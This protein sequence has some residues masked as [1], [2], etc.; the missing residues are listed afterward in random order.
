[1]WASVLW[2]Q[3]W[4]MDGHK[5]SS[6]CDTWPYCAQSQPVRAVICSDKTLPLGA[7]GAKMTS[8]V[9]E[10][11][12]G[13]SWKLKHVIAVM[14][15]G[16]WHAPQRLQPLAF[17]T[18]QHCW[19][20]I[21]TSFFVP[22]CVLILRWRT[23]ERGDF[24][25]GGHESWESLVHIFGVLLFSVWYIACWIYMHLHFLCLSFPSLAI[26]P[27]FLPSL[28]PPTLYFS[29]FP[30]HSCFPVL[31]RAHFHVSRYC[32]WR[33][34]ATAHRWFHS[35]SLPRTWSRESTKCLAMNTAPRPTSSHVSTGLFHVNECFSF[36][37]ISGYTW[38]CHAS[39]N[40]SCLWIFYAS[41]LKASLFEYSFRVLLVAI[42]ASAGP[43]L[44]CIGLFISC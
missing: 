8:L 22:L 20:H 27:S 3:T 29:C 40:V 43:I 15:F 26:P 18:M 25:F 12:V 42:L 17:G 2:P 5:H 7:S 44:I 30:P 4:F 32:Y 14:G 37:Y 21:S 34:T 24:M 38:M 11:V 41:C 10:Y 28:A 9:L 1:M 36:E 19:C 31:V 6:T 13:W 35:S 23:S 39:N 33:M 16:A